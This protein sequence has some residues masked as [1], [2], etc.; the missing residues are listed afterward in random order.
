MPESGLGL[1]GLDER[2]TLAGGSLRHGTDRSGGYVVEA[3]I[4]WH[5]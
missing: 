4:P 1:I 3:W 5:T 2:V